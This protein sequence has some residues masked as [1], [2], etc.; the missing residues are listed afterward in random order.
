VGLET[1]ALYAEID[2][3]PLPPKRRKNTY[4]TL[5]GRGGAEALR[6]CS[7]MPVQI[8]IFTNLDLV[9]SR[10]SRVAEM[11]TMKSKIPNKKIKTEETT[12]VT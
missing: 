8:I 3:D 10:K 7:T 5:F 2:A 9:L 6:C 12:R 4:R 11:R 1:V